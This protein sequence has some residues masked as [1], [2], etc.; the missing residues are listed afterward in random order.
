[1]L[2]GTPTSVPLGHQLRLW[3]ADGSLAM[4][5]GGRLPGSATLA[6][7]TYWSRASWRIERY[8][9]LANS[10]MVEKRPTPEEVRGRVT[11]RSCGSTARPRQRSTT[12]GS[13]ATSKKSDRSAGIAG[14]PQTIATE[15]LAWE[16]GARFIK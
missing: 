8:D 11:S 16:F 4:R 6:A 15:K 5:G 12:A 7:L 1:M 2:S 10:A 3:S 13:P 14:A 9:V